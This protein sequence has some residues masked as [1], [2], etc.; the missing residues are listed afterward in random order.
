M[1]ASL[2]AA[3]LLGL[4]AIASAKVYFKDTF[5]DGDAWKSRWVQSKNKEKDGTAGKWE[6]SA[7]KYYNDAEKDKG[8]KTTEDARF[9]HLSA[10]VPEQ[11][12]NKDKDLIVQYSVKHEQRIDCG[13]GYIKLLPSGLDQSDFNGDSAYNI[14]FG[15]DICGSS[16]KHT[17]L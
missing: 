11:F 1:K 14:M 17:S 9:Y 7:G 3:I 6:L 2:I 12:S 16:R 15:P 8:I 4:L 5:E 10:E 13:G